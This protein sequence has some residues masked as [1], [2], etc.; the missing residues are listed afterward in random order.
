MVRLLAFL[1]AFGCATPAVAHTRSQSAS[2]WRIEGDILR[3]RVEADALD[4]TRL[5]ALGDEDEPLSEK[6]RRHAGGAFTVKTAAGACVSSG[7]ARATSAPVGRVAVEIVFRCPAHGLSDGRLDF[8]S[9]LFLDVAASHLHFAN[10]SDGAGGEGEA[11]LTDAHRTAR[12]A[13]QPEAR[14]ESAWGSFLRFLPIGA[15]H[16]WGGLDHLAFILALALLAR[17]LAPIAIAATGFTL[18]HTATLALATMGAVQPDGSTVEALIGFTV[19][20]VALEAARDGQSRMTRWSVPIA[21]CL[22]ALAAFA[23]VSGLGGAPIALAGLAVFAFAYP[24]GFKRGASSAPWLAAVFGLIHGCGFAGALNELDLPRP[25]LVSALAGF[26]VGVEFAQASVVL[27]ALAVAWAAR[28]FAPTRVGVAGE[29]IT[30]GLFGLGVFW[31]VS[32]T[33]GA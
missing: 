7:D 9:R 4:A 23:L 5:Y 1:I 20:F 14:A 21:L 30:A 17:G 13:M 18:G 32:R 11:I 25:H 15:T 31:F 22:L 6:F 26:N 10:F 16:V 24:R 29:A 28:R 2:H 19:A 8:S 33:I 27:L 3:G 12:I